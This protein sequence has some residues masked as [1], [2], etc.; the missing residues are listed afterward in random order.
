[1]NLNELD[2]DINN[3]TI[4]DILNLYNLSYNYDI[5]DLK[6]IK[7]KNNKGTSR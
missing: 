4:Y 1:M 6:E 7:K 3:Y 2:L 5:S